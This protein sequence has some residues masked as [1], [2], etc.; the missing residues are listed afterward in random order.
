MSPLL[1]AYGVVSYAVLGWMLYQLVRAPRSLP[2]RAVTSMVAC[3]ALACPFGLAAD[4][5]A[6][7]I[8]LPPMISRLVQHSLLLAAVNGLACFFLFS[9]LEA[10]PAIRRARLY[11]IPL[12]VAVSVLTLSAIMTPAGART[13]D[14]SVPSVGV[15]FLTADLY[16]VFGFTAALIW[17][18]RYADG[19]EPRLARGLRLASIGLAGIVMADCVF[20]PT[21]LIRLTGGT[22]AGWFVATGVVLLLSGIVTFLIGVSYPAVMMW[23][24]GLRVWRQHLRSYRELAPLWTTLHAQFPEDALNRVSAKPWLDAVS[25][26]GVHRRY[27]R[28]VI[29][30]R[31]GLVRIS[32]YLAALDEHAEPLAA[33]LKRALSARIEGEPV[34]SQP[35][36]VAVP[37]RGGLDADVRELVAL[38]HALRQETS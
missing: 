3:W 34:S 4:R 19:A 2:L 1:V 31:D 5:S 30:C 18:R 28:R 16:M 36:M 35:I 10:R 6:V 9:A 20:V 37:D 7:I 24:Q 32:P 22:A 21:V 29:E 17:T 25:L 33:R 12:A 15:F 11:L 38:S 26:R 27:Y 23:L 8:G 13:D 14:H